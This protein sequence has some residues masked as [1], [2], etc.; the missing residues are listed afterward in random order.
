VRFSLSDPFPNRLQLTPRSALSV[1]EVFPLVGGLRL[2]AISPGSLS[3]SST[4]R[5]SLLLTR[6]PCPIIC[7][8]GLR[9]GDRKLN[10]HRLQ[11]VAHRFN[12]LF[13]LGKLRER[14]VCQ[15][16]RDIRSPV[17]LVSSLFGPLSARSRTSEG[18]GAAGVDVGVINA[19]VSNATAIDVRLTPRQTLRRR[20]HV[21]RHPNPSQPVVSWLASQAMT[22]R[23]AYCCSAVDTPCQGQFVICHPLAAA[24]VAVHVIAPVTDGRRVTAA[25]RAAP[26][27]NTGQEAGP[28]GIWR[29][30]CPATSHTVADGASRR[31]GR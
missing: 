5:R 9:F 18:L 23:Q 29:C 12:S 27:Q 17:C 13:R 22:L 20:R 25:N 26:T 15:G 1:E 3:I 2:E 28:V 30:C 11:L 4:F 16:N 19:R 7:G 6:S 21:I 10:P 8:P 14:P 24:G 31:Q